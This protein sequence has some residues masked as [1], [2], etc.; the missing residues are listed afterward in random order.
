VTGF[1]VGLGTAAALFYAYKKNQKKV[2]EWLRRRG[3]HLPKAGGADPDSLSLED[4]VR[5]KE[6]LEDLIAEREHAA[7]QEVGAGSEAE[8]TAK[9][10]S[11][12]G[13]APASA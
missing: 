3:I 9:P 5:E 11:R 4:L 10:R 13:E 2:D 12:R 6:R 7:A 8:D 1:V